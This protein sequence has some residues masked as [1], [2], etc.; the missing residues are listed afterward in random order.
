MS[1]V[2]H[3]VLSELKTGIVQS[4]PIK[5]LLSSLLQHKIINHE[6][7][8]NLKGKK[9]MRVLISKLHKKDFQTFTTFVQCILEAGGEDC[10]VNTTIVNCIRGAAE[11]FD[12]MHNTDFTPQIPRKEYDPGVFDSDDEEDSQDDKDE[13]S[14]STSDDRASSGYA[15]NSPGPLSSTPP[16][17]ESDFTTDQVFTLPVEQSGNSPK[18]V[19]SSAQGGEGSK[20]DLAD[21][22]IEDT[23]NGKL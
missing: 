21:D 12:S 5:P 22:N 8:K 9:G 15:S 14:S 7:E 3:F 2:H 18:A 16:K 10:S 17:L 6:E 23:V 4:V 1:E 11:N 13:T 20:A 19:N